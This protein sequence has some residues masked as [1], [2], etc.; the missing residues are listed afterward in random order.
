M[1]RSFRSS[2]NTRSRPARRVTLNNVYVGTPRDCV[3]CHRAAYDRTTSPPH[4]AA[5]FGTSCETCHKA[6]DPSFR[7]AAFN[8]AT[9]FPLVGLHA[10]QA[11]TACHK[12]NVYRGTPRDCV[13]CHRTEY[14][15]TTSPPHASA[16]FGTSCETC[17]KATDSSFRGATFNHN[18]VFALVGQHASQACTACHKNNVYK[19]TPRDCV[20]CHRD[21]LRP[22]D[23]ARARGGGLRHD[24]RDVSSGHRL[25]VAA[26]HVQSPLPDHGAA[27]HGLHVVP[28]G[29]SRTPTSRA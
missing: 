11:C 23:L 17:H 22:D 12:N 14:D 26:G 7:G 8:H 27:Q 28:P 21:Q 10:Q 16:G 29:R 3:G 6:A 19:G 2:G 5:G 20:A 15:R 24:V 1:R 13:G 18:T 25:D 9:V 4:A